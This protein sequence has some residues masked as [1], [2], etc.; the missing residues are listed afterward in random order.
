MRSTEVQAR[1]TRN[2]V[3]YTGNWYEE[4]SGR[5]S[6]GTFDTQEE[7]AFRAYGE[8][9]ITTSQDLMVDTKRGY[10]ANLR[11]Y[12][13]TPGPSRVTACWSGMS[14]RMPS[15]PCWTG[16]PP[17]GRGCS[18]LPDAHRASLRRGHRGPLHGLPRSRER[19]P[20]VPANRRRRQ[21]VFE[22]GP[23]PNR[24]R[25]LGRHQREQDRD[26]PPV[27]DRQAL[28]VGHREPPGPRR[29][30]LAKDLIAPNIRS[31]T[32]AVQAGLSAFTGT[33]GRVHQHGTQHAYASGGCRC[34]E[35]RMAPAA[36][37]RGRKSGRHRKS[38]ADD[39]IAATTWSCA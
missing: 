32:Q 20:D 26:P 6:A 31:R 21:E 34:E 37:D 4:S 29:P 10:G 2:G 3:R 25:D 27:D 15:Y 19:E 18:R 30:A 35:C 28:R 12:V 7:A 17:T 14:R 9:C 5:H 11:R 24:P 39:H 1:D 16:S 22:H 33:D 8:R 36:Y 23:I 13:T 38:I